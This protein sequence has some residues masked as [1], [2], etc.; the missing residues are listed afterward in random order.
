MS[1]N[2]FEGSASRMLGRCLRVLSLDLYLGADG[3]FLV[4]YSSYRSNDHYQR[5]RVLQKERAIVST[6]AGHWRRGSPCAMSPESSAAA[7][8]AHRVSLFLYPI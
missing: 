7:A 6:A 4:R 2:V 8:L 3:T 5:Q 1:M